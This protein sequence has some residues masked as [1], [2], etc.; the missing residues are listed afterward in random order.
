MLSAIRTATVLIEVLVLTACGPP[1][2]DNVVTATTPEPDTETP[3]PEP[4]PDETPE[5][6]DETEEPEAVR[7][8]ATAYFVRDEPS[9]RVPVEPA[10]GHVETAPGAVGRAAMELL[11]SGDV[12]DPNLFTLAPEGTDVLDVHIDDGVMI[13][14][15]S[16][17]VVDG[18]GGSANE[19]AFSQQLAH[20]AAQFDGVDAVRVR[21]NGQERDLWGH[22]DWT[23][24]IEPDPHALSPIIVE[25]PEWDEEVP[26][27]PLT[28]TGN[29]LTFE[30]NVVLHL[31]DPDEELVE[32]TFT[33]A[34]QRAVDERG[35]FEHTFDRA[36]DRPGRW[37]IDAIAQDAAS[38]G[39][40]LGDFVA[41]VEFE[42]AG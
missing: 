6:D 21:V 33:T 11:V 38:P 17:D 34:H 13:V 40:G 3:E 42:V 9:D 20:T 7:Q 31:Y 15:L 10:S 1:A 23:Q 30:A 24:P 16:D 25:S 26:S 41:T 2:D 28:V 27:G 35:P 14:D 4:T 36:L 5:P 19:A 39:E 22:V 12:A 32:D 18:P 8:E 29:S 37:R